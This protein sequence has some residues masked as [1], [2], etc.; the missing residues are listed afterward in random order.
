MGGGHRQKTKL[1]EVEANRT[2]PRVE[3]RE[4]SPFWGLRQNG[5]RKSGEQKKKLEIPK[6]LSPPRRRKAPG[7]RMGDLRI[8]LQSI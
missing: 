1:R 6:N 7:G 3:K 4:K 2:S 5:R 8:P